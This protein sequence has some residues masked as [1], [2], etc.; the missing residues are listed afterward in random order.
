MTKIKKKT[1]QEDREAAKKFLMYGLGIVLLL[2][3][4]L[5]FVFKG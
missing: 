5:Y 2:M 1:N 3:A 4:L